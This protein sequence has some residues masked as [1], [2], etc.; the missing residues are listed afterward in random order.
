MNKRIVLQG[1]SPLKNWLC[2]LGGTLLYILSLNLF[3]VGNNIAAG[4][5][6]G[7][8]VV[9]RQV[10]P[11]GVGT[12]VYIMNVPILL[13]AIRINGLH[14]TIATVV[15]ATLYSLGIDA[16]DFLPTLTYEPMM[17]ALGGGVLYG[18]GMMLI[19]IGHGSTGGTDL[20]CRL[21]L[22]ALPN[23]SL[24]RMSLL[25]DG[26]VVVLAMVIFGNVEAGLYA[27]LT[28]YVCSTTCDKLLM[29]FDS[30]R[31]C[32]I[33]TRSDAHTIADPL[34]SRTGRAVT[35]LNGTG[36][37]TDAKRNVLLMAVR[38]GEVTALKMLLMQLDP[39]AFVV[40]LPANE[41]IGGHFQHTQR[42]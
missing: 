17:A 22:K 24:G 12:M 23:L 10:I 27:I 34:M 37:Y 25:I 16:L 8:A 28:L 19:T 40:L 14:Y 35:L 38:P 9:L 32:M 2:T 20:L 13:A 1:N 18:L 36:M 6:S 7:L 42:P 4:G 39:D 15:V 31:M 30:G 41:L 29:G 11:I 21:L 33:I 5:L 26:G 3:L